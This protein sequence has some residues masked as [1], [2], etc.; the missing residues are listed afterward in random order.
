MTEK[1]FQFT[2]K[3]LNFKKIAS[4]EKKIYQFGEISVN[5]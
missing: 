2:K 1:S 4:I 5:R 3:N